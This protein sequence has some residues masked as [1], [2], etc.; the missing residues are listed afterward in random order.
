MSRQVPTS[1]TRLADATARF[2]SSL[3]PDAIWP[4]TVLRPGAMLSK[5]LPD[6]AS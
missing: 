5:V 3:S 1:N 2:T 6:A 4:I